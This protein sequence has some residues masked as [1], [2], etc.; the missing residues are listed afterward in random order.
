MKVIK[1]YP[2]I[3]E[4]I[5]L[6][7][8]FFDGIHL[9]HREIIREDEDYINAVVTFDKHPLE[10]IRGKSPE[11][12]TD[13]DEKVKMLE[14]CSVDYLYILPFDEE[15]MRLTPEKFMKKILENANVKKIRVGFNF[16]F[17][18]KGM[19]DT[20]YLRVLSKKMG[21]KLKVTGEIKKDG[22]TISSTYIRNLIKKG[23]VKKARVFLGREYQLSGE[24]F[25]G[26]EL[27]KTIGVPTANIY[28]NPIK[29][30]PKFGVY[31]TKVIIEGFDKEYYGISNVGINPTFNENVRVE[32]NIF[33]F[34]EDIYGKK[35]TVKFLEF[36]RE[37]TDF[38]SVEKLKEQLKR[39][40]AFGREVEKGEF[41]GK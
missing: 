20:N 6:A 3:K 7:L 27:G 24:V 5:S 1:G 15:F 13:A 29:V 8:G 2:N 19:G 39:D 38:G 36:E 22:N 40:I 4:E 33:D 28:P 12:L 25:K 23:D 35:V 18:Y 17:G 30:M 10:L 32:T 26:K 9:G 41:L 16:S 31:A 21:F 37:E 14:K 11:F 34:D